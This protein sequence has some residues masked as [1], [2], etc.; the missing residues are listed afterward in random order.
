[1]YS[2]EVSR[3]CCLRDQP[4][5]IERLHDILRQRAFLQI[6]KVSF[7]LT[8]AADADNDTIITTLD[9]GLK[10][11]VVNCP[12][13]RNLE[14]GQVV[15]FCSGFNN[16]ECIESALLE[17]ALTIHASNAVGLLAEATVVGDDVCRFDLAREQTASKRVVD[18]DV[19]FVLAAKWDELRLD[20]TS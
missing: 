9:S 8:K 7:K 2:A 5:F 12:S 18:N 6:C 17:V 4:C 16:L 15:L 14:Q 1:M 3:C 13:Q 20:S 11:R 19:N 10:V